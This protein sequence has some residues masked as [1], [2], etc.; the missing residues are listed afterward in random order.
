MTPCDNPRRSPCILPALVILTL[1]LLPPVALAQPEV[2]D[3]TIV[4]V[5][6]PSDDTP[7][8]FFLVS[9]SSDTTF[10][11]L[12]D[13]S[14]PDTTFLEL[15]VGTYE[16]WETL[17]KFWLLSV[18]QGGSGIFAP[19][20]SLIGTTITLNA[21]DSTTVTLINS[22]F[23]IDVIKTDMLIHDQGAPGADP[24]DSLKFTIHVIETENNSDNLGGVSFDLNDI[25]D[26]SM[27]LAV[28]SVQVM[29]PS[30]WSFSILDGNTSGD[31][32]VSVQSVAPVGDTTTIMFKTVITG[33]VSLFCNQAEVV[34]I[35]SARNT[36]LILSDDPDDPTSAADPTCIAA[37]EL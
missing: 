23:G 28:G 33:D 20:D 5:S 14:D 1:A 19:N 22:A 2:A 30:P 31:T 15:A 16:I 12:M 18:V 37:G 24:G 6:H 9:P 21:D 26:A 11:T 27:A 8:P 7:F 36:P 4:K 35:S 32:F 10:F 34:G 17:P 29:V 25:P 13:P 3:L